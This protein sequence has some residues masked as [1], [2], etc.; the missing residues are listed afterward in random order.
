VHG[1]VRCD[2]INRRGKLFVIIGRNTFSA[3]VCGASEIE[4]HTAAI[5]VGEPTASPPNFVGQTVE[6]QLPYS[7]M[8]VSISTLYWQNAGPLDHRTWIAPQLFTP[9]TFE[10]YLSG[11]DPALAAILDYREPPLRRHRSR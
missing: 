5:F 6:L 4:Q 9:P 1:L 7:K 10:A 2:R 3:A 11:Q 8:L